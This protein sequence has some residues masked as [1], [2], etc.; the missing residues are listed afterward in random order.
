[1]IN[2]E[3]DDDRQIWLFSALFGDNGVPIERERVIDDLMRRKREI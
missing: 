2:T 3:W 1:V